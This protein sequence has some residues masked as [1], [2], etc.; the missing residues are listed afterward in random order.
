M[1]KPTKTPKA[2][3]ATGQCPLIRGPRGRVPLFAGRH[4]P[5]KTAESESLNTRACAGLRVRQT[6]YPG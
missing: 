2:A 4:F 1:M 5:P 3:N 6:Q